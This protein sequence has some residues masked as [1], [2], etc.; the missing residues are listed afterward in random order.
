MSGKFLV[1]ARIRIRIP[2]RASAPAMAFVQG[3][4]KLYMG[5]SRVDITSVFGEYRAGCEAL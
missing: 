2:I 1:V 4:L 5:F 3:T